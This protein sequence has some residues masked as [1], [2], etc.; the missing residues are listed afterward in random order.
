MLSKGQGKTM[1]NHYLLL[2]ALAQEQRIEEAEELWNQIFKRH[3][4]YVPRMFFTRVITMYEQNNMPDKL[5]EVFHLSVLYLAKWS[6]YC[7][8]I[9][10]GIMLMC[11]EIDEYCT[12]VVDGLV[13]STTEH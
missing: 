8:F 9:L 12:F 6:I 13:S 10:Q 11:R 3:L 5:I 2:D 7:I 4:E 1:G